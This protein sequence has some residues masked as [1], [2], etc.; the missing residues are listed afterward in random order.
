[1]MFPFLIYLRGGK[2]AFVLSVEVSYKYR[3]IYMDILEKERKLHKIVA[4]SG[5]LFVLFML[6]L[7]Q[8][9]ISSGKAGGGSSIAQNSQNQD[10]QENGQVAGASTDE[11]ILDESATDSNNSNNSND[12]KAFASIEDCQAKKS[13]DLADL[14]KFSNGKKI[15][16]K[17]AYE[18]AVKPYKEAL[19][20][21]VGTP[22]NIADERGALDQL[23]SDQY[24]TYLRKL[25][26]VERAVSSQKASI[27]S[28]R[29]SAEAE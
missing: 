6:P 23:I 19:S 20:K 24:A 2:V 9:S 17:D 29:C 26:E 4:A 8:Y 1:M 27:D 11:S 13:K 21:I 7:I 10:P 16:L 3:K 15:A 14:E 28:L 12:S 5:F 25:D 22:K 18:T